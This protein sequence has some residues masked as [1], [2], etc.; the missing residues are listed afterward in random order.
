MRNV[1]IIARSIG[2]GKTHLIAQAECFA[3]AVWFVDPVGES[4]QLDWPHV[5]K[6]VWPHRDR[7]VEF[8]P[9]NRRGL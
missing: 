3:Q 6:L 8:N 7:A 5:N 1:L 4:N 2:H 9:L